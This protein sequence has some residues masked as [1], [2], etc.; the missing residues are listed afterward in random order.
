MTTETITRKRLT[1]SEG[2]LLTNGKSYVKVAVIPSEAAETK[3]HEVSYAK[4]QQ[5]KA[6]EQ[7]KKNAS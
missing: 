5:I 3:Y 7:A 2:M 4:Y 1:A 6:E